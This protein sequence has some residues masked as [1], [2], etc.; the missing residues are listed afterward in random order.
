MHTSEPRMYCGLKRHYRR[1]GFL[2]HDCIS[3]PYYSSFTALPGTGWGRRRPRS[4]GLAAASMG[5]IFFGFANILLIQCI[6]NMTLDGQGQKLSSEASLVTIEK[7]TPPSAN[8]FEPVAIIGTGEVYCRLHRMNSSHSQGAVGQ[9]TATNHQR[10]GVFLK[11][12]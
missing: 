1:G 8:T 10:C 2:L 7:T 5:E 6:F 4:G 12:K 3:D 11:N 9:G